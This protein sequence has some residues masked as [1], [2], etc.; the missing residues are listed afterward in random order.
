MLSIYPSPLDHLS[1]FLL[2]RPTFVPRYVSFLFFPPPPFIT[3]APG[4]EPVVFK[5]IFIA[6]A[7][8]TFATVL[9]LVWALADYK[10]WRLL[11]GKKAVGDVEQALLEAVQ[12][13][14]AT[15]QLLLEELKRHAD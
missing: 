3:M 13:L 11:R 1:F 2:S 4:L 6:G 12:G 8:G 14:N 10:G 9:I 5:G 15:S 7:V